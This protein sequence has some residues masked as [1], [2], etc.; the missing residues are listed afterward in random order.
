MERDIDIR[1][2]YEPLFPQSL[3]KDQFIMAQI[4]TSPNGRVISG[5]Y[6]Q[7]CLVGF[8]EK[9]SVDSIIQYFHY[10]LYDSVMI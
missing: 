1:K 3:F 10:F 2:K 7:C 6:Y 9:Q 8:P 5:R 4:P